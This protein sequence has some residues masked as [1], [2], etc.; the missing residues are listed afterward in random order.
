M[1]KKHRRKSLQYDLLSL[2]RRWVFRTFP[3]LTTH[4][5]REKVP[6][7]GKVEDKRAVIPHNPPLSPVGRQRRAPLSL[8]A[9]VC[10]LFWNFRGLPVALRRRL[11]RGHVLLWNVTLGGG[12]TRTVG[13]TLLQT[14]CTPTLSLII[15]GK[16]TNCVCLV[17]VSYVNI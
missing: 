9:S 11:Q 2:K 3:V 1:I 6:R 8:W 13:D 15:P 17:S 7:G 10:G 5:E 16:I 4:S 12:Q 14:C